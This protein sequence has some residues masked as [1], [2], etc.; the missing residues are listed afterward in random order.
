[1][2]Q[3][4]FK[5][6]FEL[7]NQRAEL[8]KFQDEKNRLSKLKYQN[9]QVKFNDLIIN[10]RDIEIDTISLKR[11]ELVTLIDDFCDFFTH[12]TKMTPIPYTDISPTIFYHYYDALAKIQTLLTHIKYDAMLDDTMRVA[13]I[14]H[15]RSFYR[16]MKNYCEYVPRPEE[17]IKKTV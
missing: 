13:D 1:M 3:P 5:G 12:Y 4:S 15:A 10:L 14:A 7:M 17:T 16:G 11:N 9:V 6:D 2:E 8:K